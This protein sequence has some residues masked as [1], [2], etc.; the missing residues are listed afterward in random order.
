MNQVFVFCTQSC[1]INY[2]SVVQYICC[3]IHH[4]CCAD[5]RDEDNRSPLHLACVGGHKD[6][7][8]YLV[9]KANCDVSE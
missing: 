4:L 7:V 6:M 3:N 5:V 1:V 2:T 8:E 9:E